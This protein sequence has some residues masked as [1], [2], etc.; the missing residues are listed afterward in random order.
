[1]THS[2]CQIQKRAKEDRY[3]I[4]EIGKYKYYA[5][6]DG[7]GGKNYNGSNHVV[8]YICENL[9]QE[10]LCND[11]TKENI[12]NTF[13]NM[14]RWMHLEEKLFGSTCTIII[15]G[16]DKIYQINLGDSKSII[17]S[18]EK[19]ISVSIDHSPVRE[20]ERIIIAG[21]KVDIGRVN[22]ILLVARAF[23]DYYLKTNKNGDL[24]IINGKVTVLPDVKVFE[25]IGVTTII[26][27]SDAPYEK[28]GFTDD[29]LVKL[30]LSA[31]DTNYPAITMAQEIDKF[32]TDDITVLVINL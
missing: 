32:T 29:D 8:D 20:K 23:G 7:H 15:V 2:V 12:E 1:M 30:Y 9:H 16:E 13:V 28:F 18:N 27:S 4:K 5:I 19:I 25:K 14:D 10:L 11:L 21:G 17:L 24:D 22:G 26:M 31:K 3:Q 6:F